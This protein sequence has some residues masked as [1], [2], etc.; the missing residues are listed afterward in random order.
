MPEKKSLQKKQV[1]PRVRA[2]KAGAAGSRAVKKVTTRK[3][4]SPRAGRLLKSAGAG[5]RLEKSDNNPILSPIGEHPW[6]AYQ[7]FNAGALLEDGKVHLVYRS[8]GHDGLSRFGYATSKNGSDIDER[9]GEPVFSA[10]LDPE[11]APAV[12]GSYS[13][14]GSWGGAEDPRLT[15]L[16]DLVYMLYTGFDHGGFPRVALTSIHKND[17]VDQKWTWECSK[18]IS[19]PGEIH[20]NW[21]LFPE[22]ING[23][24]AILHSMSPTID[25]EYL[26][27][28]DFEE[29]KY[30][31]SGYYHRADVPVKNGTWEKSIRGPGPTPI[32]TKYGWLVFYHGTAKNSGYKLGAML[33]DL[34]DPTKIITRAD[35]PILEPGEWYEREG[36]KGN[37]IYCCGAAV[38]G[39]DL[40][41][42]YGGAD[43]VLCVAKT[44][45]NEFLKNLVDVRTPKLT[46]ASRKKIS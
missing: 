11:N 44:N 45:F 42:Y 21:V 24:F 8:I 36:W 15:T 14:G 28:L 9:S 6:E 5:V 12:I 25:I 35:E 10:V 43:S 18:F 33:L 41:I 27:N 38:V 3:K 16:G 7:T 13:S 39:D 31:N 30:I 4:A 46:P 34:N 26:D 22:K 19:P 32:K 2:K 17:F 40:F 23:K 29:K 1:S 37:I 20:K